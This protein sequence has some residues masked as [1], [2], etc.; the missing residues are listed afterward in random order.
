MA[1]RSNAWTLDPAG[2]VRF[3]YL[4]SWLVLSALRTYAQE[5]T[6]GQRTYLFMWMSVHLDKGRSPWSD[7]PAGKVPKMVYK[8]SN[9]SPKRACV[10]AQAQKTYQ[11]F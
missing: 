6:H 3:P 5:Y 11:H 9:N 10:V 2:R 7:A 1:E 4:T 8:I